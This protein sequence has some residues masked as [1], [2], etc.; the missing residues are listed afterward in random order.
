VRFVDDSIATRE[1]AVAAALETTPAPIVWIAGGVD[2]GADVEP[3]AGLV[4]RARDADARHRR[5]AEPALCERVGAWTRSERIDASDGRAGAAPSVRRA[6]EVL[7]ADH[8]AAAACSWRRSR[9]RSTSSATTATAATPSARPRR[10]R[11]RL[12]ATARRGCRAD[13]GGDVDP[14]LLTLQLLLGALGVLGVAAAEPGEAYA[15]ALR[16]GVACC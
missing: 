15:Q 14:L 3:R 7:D 9:R 16:F 1:L 2:K 12:G 10:A 8:G 5:A 11:A 4:S 13:E 6:W